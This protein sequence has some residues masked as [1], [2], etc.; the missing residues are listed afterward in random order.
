MTDHLTAW[1][2]RAE[3]VAANGVA[4]R[5]IPGAGASLARVVVP[6]G[7]AAARHSHDHEQFVQVLSGSG[8]LETEQG[9]K[10][11]SAGSVFHFPAG[12]WHAA[13]FETETVLIETNLGG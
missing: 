10:P 3:S 4:K 2:D 11:F 6:A 1:T 8:F 7:T 9:R 12:T 13:A 5:A